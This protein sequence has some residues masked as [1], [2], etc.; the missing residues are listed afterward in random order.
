[1]QQQLVLANTKNNFWIFYLQEQSFLL[2]TS[3]SD[4]QCSSSTVH[5]LI[6]LDQSADIMTLEDVGHC[7]LTVCVCQI[8]TWHFLSIF[9]SGCYTKVSPFIGG[10]GVIDSRNCTDVQGHVRWCTMMSKSK[11]I[12]IYKTPSKVDDV[13]CCM[14]RI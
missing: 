3:N 6:W 9:P 1:M 7:Q 4:P 8:N 10:D 11:P 2:R 5:F 14:K 13:A 12:T